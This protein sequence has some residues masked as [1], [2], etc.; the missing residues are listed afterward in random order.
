MAKGR[1]CSRLGWSV[2]TSP[3]P[4]L[5]RG[6][7]CHVSLSSATD[8]VLTWPLSAPPHQPP[9][10]TVLSKLTCQGLELVTWVMATVQPTGMGCPPFLPMPGCSPESAGCQKLAEKDAGQEEKD[11]N[12]WEGAL[13]FR[14]VPWRKKRGHVGGHEG[15]HRLESA[16]IEGMGRHEELRGLRISPHPAPSL[17]EALRGLGEP[18][19]RRPEFQAWI[20]LLTAFKQLPPLLSSFLHDGVVWCVCVCMHMCTSW[21]YSQCLNTNQE[22]VGTDS[23]PIREAGV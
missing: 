23:G 2:Q 8:R 20:C 7:S 3:G 6:S 1:V 19:V 10:A 22:P 14:K 11:G 17:D 9:A 12:G 15:T 13:L 16:L 4:L 18:V 21:L 5:H